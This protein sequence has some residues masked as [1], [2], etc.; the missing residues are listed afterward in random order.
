M[1]SYSM[2]IL[3]AMRDLMM[4]QRRKHASHICLSHLYN[5]LKHAQYTNARADNPTHPL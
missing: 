3:L 4:Q 1:L 5:N 2:Q